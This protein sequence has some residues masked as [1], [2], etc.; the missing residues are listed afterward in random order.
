MSVVLLPFHSLPQFSGLSA[1][2]GGRA[3]V[4]HALSHGFGG[5]MT[6]YKLRDWLISRQRYWGTPIP[7]LYCDQCGVSQL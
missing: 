5:H 1:E 6:Q 3:I 2:E 7:V 4:E